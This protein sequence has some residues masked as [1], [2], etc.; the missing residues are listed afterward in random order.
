VPQAA[1]NEIAQ[2][3]LRGREKHMTR[4]N[5][6]L[7]S[8]F[9]MVAMAFAAASAMASGGYNSVNAITGDPGIEQSNSSG[10]HSTVNALTGDRAS[11]QS[12]QPAK[13]ALQPLGYSSE[14]ALTGD[15]GTERSVQPAQGYSSL[16]AITGDRSPQPVSSPSIEAQDEGGFDWGDA[17][18]GALVASGLLGLTFAAASSVARHRRTAA[19]PRV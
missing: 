1:R 9:A 19:E 3:D 10:D 5:T 17:L 12:G 15:P 6:V 18:I 13:Q 16:T 8:I 4:T 7:I 11:Q 14:T 2:G